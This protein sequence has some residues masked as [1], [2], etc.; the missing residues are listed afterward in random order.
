MPLLYTFQA[1][2]RD[3]GQLPYPLHALADG[4]IQQK[5]F[6]KD[7]M[8]KLLGFATSTDPGDSI[9]ERWLNVHD[10]ETTIGKYMVYE[11]AEGKRYVFDSAVQSV[12]IRS[13]TDEQLEHL[14]G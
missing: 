8:V 10:P 14:N 7:T 2:R 6:W 13:F 11:N 4:E 9:L 3:D 12:D 5:G 1:A